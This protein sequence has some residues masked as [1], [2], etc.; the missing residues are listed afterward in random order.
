MP[1][2]GFGPSS[3]SLI[4][5]RGMGTH[6]ACSGLAPDAAVHADGA[7]FRDYHA[8]HLGWMGKCFDSS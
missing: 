5:F 2:L 4:S 6:P 3:L 8:Q 1:K 7:I